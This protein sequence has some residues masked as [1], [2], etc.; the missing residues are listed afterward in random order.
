MAIPGMTDADYIKD[1]ELIDF[2]GYHRKKQG[3]E[4]PSED[5]PKFAV[6]AFTEDEEFGGREMATALDEAD[7]LGLRLIIAITDRET[8]V[9]YY[10]AKRIELPG[11]RNRYYE[12]E[13]DQP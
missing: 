13:W 2:I 5:K 4:K 11:S 7:K 6:V 12:I 9:T 8:A 3:I 10:V 1:K